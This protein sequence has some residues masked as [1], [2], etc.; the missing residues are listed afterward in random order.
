M[1]E[2]TRERLA[3]ASKLI[4]SGK[5]A[6]AIPLLD[7]II[8]DEPDCAFAWKERGY[9]KEFT[10][11]YAGA[12]ADCTE[13]TQRWPG[14]PDG[15]ARRASVRAKAS[16]EQGAI[17]DYSAAIAINSRHSYAM[18]QRGRVKAAIG[19]FDGAIA[20][21][22]AHMEFSENGPLSGL[23]NRGRARHRKGDLAGAID[24]LTAAIAWEDG[25]VY[26]PL[27]RGR[28]Y[29]DMRSYEQAIADFS[30]AIREFQGL[31]NA[32]RLR[33][34][35]RAAIGDETGAREDR[36]EFGRLGGRD[37]PAYE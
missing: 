22:S 13:M 6:L 37:L 11:D 36:E 35:A 19:D 16:D 25:P 4:R 9:A 10:G 15:F 21:F 23:L 18:F 27:F 20:D 26:A 8:R 7:E 17:E 12:I 24:D 33:A 3:V 2:E 5:S 28:V 31:A 14:D 32:Y 1:T 29:L 30:M 34:E